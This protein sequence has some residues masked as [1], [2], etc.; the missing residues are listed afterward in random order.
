M[1]S[2]APGD[3]D[4]SGLVDA[5]DYTVWRDDLGSE[6]ALVNDN[7]LGAPIGQAH[8]ELWKAYFGSS[9]TVTVFW[10]DLEDE[11]NGQ[12]DPTAQIGMWGALGNQGHAHSREV[13][14]EMWG[15]VWF[16]NTG[17]AIQYL[18]NVLITYSAGVDELHLRVPQA[19]PLLASEQTLQARIVDNGFAPRTG[20]VTFRSLHAGGGRHRR[21]APGPAGSRP[22]SPCGA[23]VDHRGAHDHHAPRV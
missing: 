2:G 5:A 8:Y 1:L 14:D 6:I 9:V 19:F 22:D 12:S 7:G 21:P 23:T 10:D 17:G 20:T 11:A 4:A 16:N 3:F 13:V 18:D 15:A